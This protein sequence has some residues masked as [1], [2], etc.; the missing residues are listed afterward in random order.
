[1][2]LWFALIDILQPF[3]PAKRLEAGFKGLLHA[4]AAVSVAAPQAYAARFQAFM[5]EVF[6]E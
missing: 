5:R 3:T 1:M 6:C 4:P 2:V